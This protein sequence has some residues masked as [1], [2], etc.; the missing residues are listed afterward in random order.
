MEVRPRRV[1]L[2]DTVSKRWVKKEVREIASLRLAINSAA[3]IGRVAG[4]EKASGEGRKL[5]GEGVV[6]D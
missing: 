1:N 6:V 5:R 3:L 4:G 2:Y